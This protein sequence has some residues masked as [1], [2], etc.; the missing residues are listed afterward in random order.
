M[1][2]GESVSVSMLEEDF[3]EEYVMVAEMAHVE[4][5]EPQTLAE[6]K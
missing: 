5:L 3:A 2:E 6:A 4:A 1:I